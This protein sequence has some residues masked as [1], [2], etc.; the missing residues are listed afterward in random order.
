MAN[1]YR[2]LVT[3]PYF[4][5][6]I[7]RFAEL[8][9]RENIEILSPP[10]EERVE[11]EELLRLVGDVDGA[12]CGDDRFTERVLAVA[13]RLKVIAKWGTGVDSIDREACARLGIAVRNTPGAFTDPVADSVLGYILCFARQLPWMTE[14]MKQG[15]WVKTPA[16]CLGE[17]TLGILGLGRIGSAVALRARAFGMRVLANDVRAICQEESSAVGAEMVDKLTLWRESDFLSVNCDLNLTT[18]RLINGEVLAQMKRTTVLVNTARGPIVE[19]G[20]LAEALLTGRLGGAAL[21]VFEREPLP[22]SSPLRAMGN[23]MLAA[24]NANSSPRAWERV[25]GTTLSALF[26]ELRKWPAGCERARE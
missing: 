20:A 14:R 22:S 17:C 8:F 13:P 15:D 19:E 9:R 23:V 1:R 4:K 24:H 2:V 12:L 21:D 11:E 18:D 16:R 26:E 5:P 25:H 7:E 10:V 6:E 3:A